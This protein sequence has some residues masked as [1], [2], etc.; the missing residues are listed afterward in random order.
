VNDTDSNSTI[1]S[2]VGDGTVSFTGHAYNLSASQFS[3]SYT[4]GRFLPAG[5]S[6]MPNGARSI[7]TRRPGRLLRPWW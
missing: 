4:Q 5:V 1:S 3:G 7:R 2:V 6:T